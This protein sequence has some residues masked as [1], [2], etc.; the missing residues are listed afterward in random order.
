[1]KKHLLY[2]FSIAIFQISLCQDTVQSQTSFLSLDLYAD[3]GKAALSFTNFETKYSVGADLTFLSHYMITAEY[4]IATL[5]PEEAYEN[6][7]YTSEGYYYKGGIGYIGKFKE[8]YKMGFGVRYG[9]SRFQDRGIITIFSD[10][11]L[12]SDYTDSFRRENLEASWAEIFFLSESKLRL[13]K[14]DPKSIMNKIFSIGFFF[15]IRKL[16]DYDSFEPIDVYNIPGYGRSID[17]SIPAI[18]LFLK[19]HVFQ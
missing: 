5:A 4:G 6:V 2:I 10:T 15:Q 11:P 12:V 7:D 18:N 17:N 16:L 8:T 1:M 3:Y 19:I 9:E 13:N 14:K